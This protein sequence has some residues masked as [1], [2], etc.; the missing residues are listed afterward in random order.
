[1]EHTPV[2][3]E[4]LLERLQVNREQHRRVFEEAME[5]F[6]RRLEEELERRLADVR[7]GRR[8]E[9]YIHLEPPEDHTKD[10]DTVIE[11]V[12]WCTQDLIVLSRQDFRAFVRDDWQWKRD[13]VENTT[14]YTAQRPD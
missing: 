1:M 3:K 9:L 5:G 14:A 4:Q 2:R 7:A 11:M 12:E 8:V 6:R 10:Y 13:W